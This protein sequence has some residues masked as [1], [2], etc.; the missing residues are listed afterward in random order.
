M[1]TSPI[2]IFLIG[3]KSDL[4]EEVN[5]NEAETWINQREQTGATKVEHVRISA[6]ANSMIEGLFDKVFAKS[7]LPI[8]LGPKRHRR[9]TVK[10]Y[11]LAVSHLDKSSRLDEHG[12]CDTNKEKLQSMTN[13]IAFHCPSER[14]PSIETEVLLAISKVRT[15]VVD[16]DVTTHDVAKVPSTRNGSKVKK[17]LCKLTGLVLH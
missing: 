14:R 3:N 15:V 1:Q 9:V 11:S 17:Q 5:L 8:E 16:S 6:K 12:N 7:N 10:E 2:T 4:P 13:A